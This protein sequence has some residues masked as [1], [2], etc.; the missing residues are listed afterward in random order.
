MSERERERERKEEKRS[1][2]LRNSNPLFHAALSQSDYFWLF[3]RV[4]EASITDQSD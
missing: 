4:R 2:G 1:W 3:S